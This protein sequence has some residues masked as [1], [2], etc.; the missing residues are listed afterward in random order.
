MHISMSQYLLGEDGHGRD[1]LLL[2]ATIWAQ[3]LAVSDSMA[4]CEDQV[5]PPI[6]V[7]ESKYPPNWKPQVRMIKTF[8]VARNTSEWNGLE[9]RIRALLVLP[10]YRM[11]Q[12]G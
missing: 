4:A 8:S 11:R 9:Q 7:Q 12:G 5:V 1:Q 2:C 6:L 3:Q 10:S